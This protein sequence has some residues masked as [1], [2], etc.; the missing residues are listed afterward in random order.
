M[1]N[2]WCSISSEN[3]RWLDVFTYIQALVVINRLEAL[4]EKYKEKLKYVTSGLWEK[5]VAGPLEIGPEFI[6][7]EKAVNII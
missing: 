2:T 6:Y 1:I 3:E 5:F 7:S 4:S